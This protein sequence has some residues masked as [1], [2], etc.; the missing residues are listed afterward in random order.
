MERTVVTALTRHCNSD[1]RG[2]CPINLKRTALKQNEDYEMMMHVALYARYHS[3]NTRMALSLPARKKCPSPSWW[4]PV[5]ILPYMQPAGCRHPHCSKGSVRAISV[6]WRKTPNNQ[7]RR[8][9]SAVTSGMYAA[10]LVTLTATRATSPAGRLDRAT[11]FLSFLFYP[12]KG[13]RRVKKTLVTAKKESA[14]AAQF[15]AVCILV[16]R[17][18]SKGKVSLPRATFLGSARGPDDPTWTA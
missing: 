13:L 3:R 15:A 1:G 2:I 4:C 18:A 17:V 11:L 7:G 5:S 9:I 8:A 6:D 14:H 10:A 12:L 16:Q